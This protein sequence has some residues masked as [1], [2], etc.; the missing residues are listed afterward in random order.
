[1]L[2]YGETNMKKNYTYIVFIIYFIL[3]IWLI[4]FKLAFSLEDIPNYN[5]INLIPFYKSMIVN[6]KVIFS[7][8]MFNVLVFMPLGVYI[9]MIL[10]KLSIYKAILIPFV[11]SI[12]LET[13]QYIFHLG[14]SD[15]TD[16]ITNILGGI[17]G[18]ILF[19]IIKKVF[20]NKSDKVVNTIGLTVEIVAIL[21]ITLIYINN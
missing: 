15:I 7:E 21:L 14:S 4:L 9:K 2:I 5:D 8:I 17:L 13:T 16:V 6:K 19:K 12:I 18:L 20:K 1:M 10:P 11:I 3:L